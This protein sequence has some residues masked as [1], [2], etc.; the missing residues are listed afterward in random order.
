MTPMTPIDDPRNAAL[1][2]L[3]AAAVALAAIVALLLLRPDRIVEVD[4]MGPETGTP[5]V[6]FDDG[7][8]YDSYGPSTSGR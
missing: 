1:N 8:E 3:L 7:Y 6:E 2:H 4:E 5:V